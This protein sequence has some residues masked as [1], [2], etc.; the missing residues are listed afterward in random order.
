MRML[1]ELRCTKAQKGMNQLQSQSLPEQQE[2]QADG[3][4]EEADRGALELRPQSQVQPA[5]SRFAWTPSWSCRFSSRGPQRLSFGTPTQLHCRCWSVC[6][7]GCFL[8]APMQ[9]ACI[10]YRFS[11]LRWMADID[12]RKSLRVLSISTT[13]HLTLVEI[14]FLPLLLV[15]HNAACSS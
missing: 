15:V 12:H 7:G 13:A 5:P 4:G 1:R 3:E 11:R 10:G 8:I 14:D 2:P 6:P 9:I